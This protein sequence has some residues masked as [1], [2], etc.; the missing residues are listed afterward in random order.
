MKPLSKPISVIANTSSEDFLQAVAA[1]PYFE[2]KKVGEE[3][4]LRSTELG[5]GN[6]SLAFA[7]VRFNSSTNWNITYDT[8][9]MV[10]WFAVILAMLIFFTYPVLTFMEWD[11]AWGEELRI[12]LPLVA[13]LQILIGL[14]GYKLSTSQLEQFLNGYLK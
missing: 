10:K 9:A 3:Y 14:F 12:G 4:Q 5:P 1:H 6:Y 11:L 13:L 2:Y 8:Y 7:K